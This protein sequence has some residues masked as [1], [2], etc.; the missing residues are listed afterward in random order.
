MAS[1]AREL[2]AAPEQ[3]WGFLAE[4]HHLADWWPGIL[5]VEPDRRGFARGARW[6]V[7]RRGARGLLQRPD[8]GLH[9]RVQT[10]TLVIDELTAGMRWDWQ[11]VGREG[12][13]RAARPVRVAIEL[14]PAG[15]GRTRVSVSVESGGWGSADRLTANTA[16]ERLYALLQTGADA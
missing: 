12:G 2:L 5:G 14:E 3:V 4:P 6:Q 10:E 7:A 8:G 1:A 11:L 16:V 15:G 13:A 9:G